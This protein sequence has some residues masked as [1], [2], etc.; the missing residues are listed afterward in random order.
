MSLVNRFLK[1]FAPLLL[2]VC[3]LL[4]VQ[5]A[6]A[7]T[8]TFTQNNFGQGPNLGSVTTT[9]QAGGSILVSVN[10]D[11]AYVIHN[12]GVG[13]NVVAGFTGIDVSSINPSSIFTKDLTSHTFDGFGSFAFSLVSNQSTAQAQATGTHTV[14]FVV[15]TTTVGGFTSASQINDFA[16]QIA[17][18][19]SSNTATGF[20]HTT[21]GLPSPSPN[22]SLL[23]GPTPEPASMILLG[24]G[25]LG[26]A[27]AARKRGWKLRS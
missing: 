5:T 18:L 11:P 24:T 23:G 12:A 19:D 22:P 3:A 16:A 25:L 21:P 13:F 2:A 14:S 10:V 7:D 15:T 6:R 9:L 8:F 17:P 27:A 20:A 26:F 1:L 4:F